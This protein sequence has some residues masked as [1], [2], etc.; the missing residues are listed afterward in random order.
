V[1]DALLTTCA[2]VALPS[3]IND[4]LDLV[5]MASQWMF[6]FFLSGACLTTILIPLVPL[7]VYTRWAALPLAIITFLNALLV[8]LG[9]VLATVMF[10]IIH[11]VVTGVS[12]VNIG[13]EIGTKMFAFMWIASGFSIAAWLLQTGL[14][15]CCASRRDV[16]R[17]KKR[18]SKHAWEYDRS[19]SEKASRRKFAFRKR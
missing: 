14:C 1:A 10:V 12:E 2:P 13:A 19:A 11:N 18:G 8:T 9:S 6:A 7:S 3:G 17:G 4:A 15:C 5:R 16:K